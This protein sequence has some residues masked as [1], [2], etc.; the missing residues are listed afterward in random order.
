MTEPTIT[1]PNCKTEIKLTESL[2][3]PLIEST[4]RQFEQRLAQKDSEIIQRE[5]AMR[6]KEKQLAEDKRRLEDQVA[7][8]VAE[9][10]KAERARV[11]AEESKKAK[12]GQCC[13]AGKQST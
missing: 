7:D 5:Q 1:C 13:R 9:Q 11:I 10:L 3:A 8:Q 2:A 4:R 12:T 6:E